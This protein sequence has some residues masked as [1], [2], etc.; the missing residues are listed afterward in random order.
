MVRKGHGPPI[1]S[2]QNL[3]RCTPNDLPTSAGGGHSPSVP[4]RDMPASCTS[5]DM[6]LGCTRPKFA[7]RSECGRTSSSRMRK[8]TEVEAE[9]LASYLTSHGLQVWWD[10][11][12]YAGDD[13]HDLILREISNAKAV[14]VIW[15]DASARSR[16]VRGEANLAAEQNKLIPSHLP[17]FDL[18]RVPI[19]LREL[20]SEPIA[21]RSK[22]LNAILARSSLPHHV[23]IGPSQTER[24]TQLEN[25]IDEE[26]AAEGAL[27]AYNDGVWAGSST[28]AIA[29]YTKAISLNSQFHEAYANRGRVNYDLGNLTEGVGDLTEAIKLKARD[30]S[31]VKPIGTSGDALF[32]R[33]VEFEYS[34]LSAYFSN[35]AIAQL[36]REDYSSALADARRSI[37]L[38]DNSALGHYACAKVYFVTRKFDDA[39]HH[40]EIALRVVP[41]F[42]AAYT[43]RGLIAFD[44][45]DLDRARKQFE[46]ALAIAPD[47][48]DGNWSHVTARA[49]LA[50]L[51]QAEA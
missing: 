5:Q 31:H 20:H 35:R 19:H 33:F 15:S 7:V 3:V 28:E 17:G 38:K 46:Q 8:Q 39:L 48:E 14:V 34:Q 10:N 36:A 24:S 22:L 51:D 18:Q 26:L 27:D 6:W 37:H 23:K 32:G 29:F 40:L 12:L 43:M 9:G 2:V 41:K 21:E 42:A 47:F 25:S 16:W 50:R 13:F 11:E 45:G 49:T 44:R 30:F 4:Q 1:N